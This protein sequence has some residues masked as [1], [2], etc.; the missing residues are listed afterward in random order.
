MSNTNPTDK[1]TNKKILEFGKPASYVLATFIG[2][3]TI[4]FLFLSP[5]VMAI[6]DKAPQT[7][8]KS[9]STKWALWGIAG[10]ITWM[11]LV[12]VSAGFTP[13][14]TEAE[15]HVES[16]IE[17]IVEDKRQ[18]AE[19]ESDIVKAY[20]GAIGASIV[21]QSKTISALE[22]AQETSPSQSNLDSLVQDLN[23]STSNVSRYSSDIAI[24]SQEYG[25][26]CS[27]SRRESFTTGEIEP[28]QIKL[29]AL[30]GETKESKATVESIR[31]DVKEKEA[32][33][34][35]EAEKKAEEAK[36][37]ETAEAEKVRKAEYEASLKTPQAAYREICAAG[38]EYAEDG[39]G[40]QA[41]IARELAYWALDLKKQ[42]GGRATEGKLRQA[43]TDGYIFED[44]SKY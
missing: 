9:Q 42:T 44:C 13:G 6:I 30:T 26:E 3:S 33:E 5:L 37:R 29:L 2:F 7:K 40:T 25:D 39:I 23:K 32:A 19:I 1:K 4:Y 15:N 34:L 35:L 14:K 38:K 28:R 12:A 22:K 41:Q 24:L 36:K 27:D 11:P 20:D 8:N 17:K 16:T 21:L 43:G 31:S 10:L 18:C